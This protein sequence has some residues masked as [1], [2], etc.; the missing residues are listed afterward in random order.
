MSL[1][2]DRVFHLM[3]SCLT[4]SRVSAQQ[5]QRV[6]TQTEALSE[7]RCFQ[8]QRYQTDPAGVVPLKDHRL[9]G[10]SWSRHSPAPSTLQHLGSKT[11]LVPQSYIKQFISVSITLIDKALVLRSSCSSRGSS[12]QPAGLKLCNRGSCH[13]F[14]LLNI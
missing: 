11:V 12:L 5:S 2:P 1:V 9:P 10:T 3:G 6:Q 8:C 7:F 13:S 4:V 14:P